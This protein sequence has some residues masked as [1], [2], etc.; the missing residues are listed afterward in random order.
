MVDHLVELISEEIAGSSMG[1]PPGTMTIA[2]LFMGAGTAGT[3][4]SA[5]VYYNGQRVNLA[6]SMSSIDREFAEDMRDE[7]WDSTAETLEKE[8]PHLE[9]QEAFDMASNE[10]VPMA[11]E[12]IATNATDEQEKV[13]AGAE[14]VSRLLHGSHSEKWDAIEPLAIDLGYS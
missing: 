1:V 13:D 2:K 10:V 4:A 12:R 7:L 8:I 11:L 3:A 9:H 14:F 6:D 5:H